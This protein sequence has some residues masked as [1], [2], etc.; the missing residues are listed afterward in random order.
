MEK[1]TETEKVSTS[2]GIVNG[3]VVAVSDKAQ[4]FSVFRSAILSKLALD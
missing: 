4:L 3:N 2:R 1:G